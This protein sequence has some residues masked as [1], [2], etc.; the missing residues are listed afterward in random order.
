[1]KPWLQNTEIPYRPRFGVSE[2]DQNASGA[3]LSPAGAVFVG[4]HGSGDVKWRRGA[5][6][7]PK[8]LVV[9][10]LD[11]L[12]LVNLVEGKLKFLWM[13]TVGGEVLCPSD[14]IFVS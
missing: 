7:C 5:K 11:G 4:K 6:W 1:M 10:C 13:Y 9:H 3:M 14:I 2:K 8:K 12:N